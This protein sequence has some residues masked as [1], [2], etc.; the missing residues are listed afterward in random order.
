MTI[1]ALALDVFF[2]LFLFLFFDFEKN[3]FTET[4]ATLVERVF[5]VLS[6]DDDARCDK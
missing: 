3:A 2:F 4:I 6:R 5:D 1:A